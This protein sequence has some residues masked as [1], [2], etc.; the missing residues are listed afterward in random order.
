MVIAVKKDKRYEIHNP[1]GSVKRRWQVYFEMIEFAR[2]YMGQVPSTRWLAEKLSDSNAK[3]DR[4]DVWRWQ[5]EL[6]E[7]GVLERHTNGL[8][9]VVDSEWIPPEDS[10]DE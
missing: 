6:I 4:K 1:D 3:V 9:T 7:L 2:Q 8:I 10:I 5:Q